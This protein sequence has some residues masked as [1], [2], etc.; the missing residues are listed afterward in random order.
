MKNSLFIISKLC[1][2][3]FILLL[4]QGC[5]EDYEMID[6]P[7]MTDYD[8]DLDEEVIMQKGLESYFVTQFGEGEMDGS[9]WEQALDVAGF[10]KLLSG[11]VD[12]SKSTIY[13]SQGKYV[14]SEESGLG[15]IVRKNVKAIKGGYSQFSEGTDVSARDIDTYVTVISGDVNGNKQADAGDCG[16]LLVKKGH[17]TIEG[18]VSIQFWGTTFQAS[19]GGRSPKNCATKLT[20]FIGKLS[21]EAGS[22]NPFFPFSFLSSVG[23]SNPGTRFQAACM[24]R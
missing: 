12:L 18:V 19:A 6:P 8:D 15:V 9:S 3:A 21:L 17:I 7:L 1:M 20:I 14:M 16:L 2:L 4:A 23:R 5:Q 22:H 10:R 13:M 11:S 24:S